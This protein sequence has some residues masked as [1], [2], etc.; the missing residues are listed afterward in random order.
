[1]NAPE[2]AD[3]LVAVQQGNRTAITELL[4]RYEHYLRRIIHIR[5]TDP[6]LRRLFETMDI[7]QSVVADF[8]EWVDGGQGVFASAEK[9]RNCLVTMVLNK[10]K[11]K[12][13]AAK[14]RPVSL[15]TRQE[16]LA[17]G[18]SPDQQVAWK[19]DVAAIRAKLTEEEKRLLDARAEGRSFKEI[20]CH[21]GGNADALRMRYNRLILRLQ[22]EHDAQ[23]KRHE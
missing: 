9:V 13:R 18:P 23:G 12:A 22:R 21:T 11:A 8:L 4:P 6:C 2:F 16:L 14:N 5:L 15:P 20:A 10:I 1:M 19:Q 3:F 17:Q 7:Y